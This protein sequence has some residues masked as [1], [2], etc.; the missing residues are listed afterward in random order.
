MATSNDIDNWDVD[1]ALNIATAPNGSPEGTPAGTLNDTMRQVMATIRAL[2]DDIVNGV[3]P[4]RDSPVPA[5]QVSTLITA[6]GQTIRGNSSGAAEALDIGAAGY[7]M[8]STGTDALWRADAKPQGY[9]FGFPMSSA[10]TATTDVT[11]GPGASR[12]PGDLGNMTAGGTNTKD[13]SAAFADGSGNGGM[14]SGTAPTNGTLHVHLIN[15]SDDSKD[16]G[17]SETAESPTLPAGYDA[18]R[19]VGCVL[20]DGSALVRPFVQHGD[21]FRLVSPITQTETLSDTSEATVTLAVPLG[22]VT[23]LILNIEFEPDSAT[24]STLYVYGPDVNESAP[25]IQSPSGNHASTEIR[26]LT[27]TSGQIKMRTDNAGSVVKIT[28]LGWIDQRGRLVND[29]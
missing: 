1:P 26:L 6:R 21:Q 8:T 12:T 5:N 22:V 28:P 23:E 11:I 7:V 24:A 19:R 14:M 9:I 17:F 13:V 27:N 20:T 18:S 25:T 29:I 4:G 3:L 10:A 2:K 15:Q 16:Y